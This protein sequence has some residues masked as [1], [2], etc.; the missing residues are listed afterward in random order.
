MMCY[1]D[2]TFCSFDNCEKFGTCR[3]A[4]TSEVKRAAEAWWVRGGGKPED[5]PVCCFADMPGCHS[6]KFAI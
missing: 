1:K 5:T 3:R 4:Y 6:K 2:T